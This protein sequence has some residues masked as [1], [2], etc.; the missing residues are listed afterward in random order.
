MYL[1]ATPAAKMAPPECPKLSKEKI[2]KMRKW[3]TLSS[4]AENILNVNSLQNSI[5]LIL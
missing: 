5:F 4:L 1:S 2:L 3:S